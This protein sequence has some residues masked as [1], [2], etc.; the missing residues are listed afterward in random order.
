MKTIIFV[1]SLMLIGS[2]SAVAE[3]TVCPMVSE[4][5]YKVA[6]MRDDGLTPKDAF[7]ILVMAGMP[8]DVA[9]KVVVAIYVA[10]E[11]ESPTEVGEV[12]LEKCLGDSL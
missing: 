3:E 8:T 12:Y 9:E 1:L 4:I 5:A 10:L 6:H 7:D 2:T 11:D